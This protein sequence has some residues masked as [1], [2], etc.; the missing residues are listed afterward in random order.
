MAEK[1][2]IEELILYPHVARRIQTYGL[3]Y[4]SAYDPSRVPREQI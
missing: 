2:E 1:A 3:K 4:V